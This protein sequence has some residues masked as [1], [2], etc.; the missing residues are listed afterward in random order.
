MSVTVWLMNILLIGLVIALVF[1]TL[2]LI[3]QPPRTLVEGVFEAHKVV[4]VGGVN[5]AGVALVE[6]ILLAPKLPQDQ[7]AFV[8]D[9]QI[10]L[11]F[12]ALVGVGLFSAALA[13]RT[14]QVSRMDWW[15][16][17]QIV[18][19]LIVFGTATYVAFKYKYIDFLIS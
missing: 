11:V 18:L 12:D 9:G 2:K 10:G 8:I 1:I 14:N 16:L 3:V 4:L 6:A 15:F 17:L 19:G 13:R 5:L 7:L